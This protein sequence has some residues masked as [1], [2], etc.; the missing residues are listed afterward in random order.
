[1]EVEIILDSII[2]GVRVTTIRAKYPVIIHAEVLKHR[3][4][5]VSAS[6]TRAIPALKIIAEVENN[7]FMPKFI[8]AEKPGMSPGEGLSTM[9]DRNAKALIE[10]LMYGSINTAKKL[11]ALGV[12]KSVVNRYLMPW[13]E[14]N[15]L[16]TAATPHWEHFNELRNHEAADPVMQELARLIRAAYLES[17]PLV[18]K[19]HVPYTEKEK[20]EDGE[21]IYKYEDCLISAARCARL[22]YT[23]FGS[24]KTNDMKDLELANKLLLNN[25]ATPLE[26]IVF[27]PDYRLEHGIHYGN[28]AISSKVMTFREQI[29]DTGD[30]SKRGRKR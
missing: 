20:Q 17:I 24:P 6:S 15:T 28:N 27:A 8:G 25:H 2:N 22:S 16:T 3:N 21:Y 26:H 12:H 5:A 11:I 14:I 9:E 30:L 29:E 18:R 7:P 23:P 1:M 4:C 13:L 19:E 10:N